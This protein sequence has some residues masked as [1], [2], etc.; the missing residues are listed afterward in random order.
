VHP[1]LRSPK[2]LATSAV[3]QGRDTVKLVTQISS[4]FVTFV[5]SVNRNAR[6]ERTLT[7]DCLF[8]CFLT[9]S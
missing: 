2:S 1:F 7:S 6:R 9:P 3:F 5:N 4:H 8:L